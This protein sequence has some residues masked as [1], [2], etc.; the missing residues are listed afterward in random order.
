MPVPGTQEHNKGLALMKL[1]IYRHVHDIGGQGNGVTLKR[2][3]WSRHLDEAR[4]GA[5]WIT[6]EEDSRQMEENMKMP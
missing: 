6:E 4:E 3:R 5:L 2:G 1:T